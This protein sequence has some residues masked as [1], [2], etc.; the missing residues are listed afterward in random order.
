M[1][2]HVRDT[3][4][5]IVPLDR[6]TLALALLFE[7]D[8]AMA[9]NSNLLVANL[10]NAWA[11][12]RGEKLIGAGGLAPI[13]FGR[14]EAWMLVSGHARRREIVAGV[15]LARVWLDRKALLPEF[16][17]IEIWVRADAPWRMSFTRALGFHEFPALARAHGMDG[18]DFFM[19]ARVAN[20][21]GV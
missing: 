10:N 8:Q 16:N 19:H 17:R 4:M 11:C 13:W 12:W 7:R 3:G 2:M 1:N 6:K 21:S 20:R 18:A 14:A 15:R 5:R 9:N